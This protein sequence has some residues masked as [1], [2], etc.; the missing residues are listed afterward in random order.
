MSESN[1]LGTKSLGVKNFSIVVMAGDGIGKEVMPPCLELIKAAL[2]RVEANVAFDFISVAAG[3]EYY[4]EYGV[5]ISEQAFAQCR[6]AD[7]ILLGAMGMPGVRY[8]NGTEI[9]PQLELRERLDLFA[10]VRPVRSINGLSPPVL[11][12]ERAQAIDFVLIRESV[13]GL[14]SARKKEQEAIDAASDTL[15]C[16]RSGTE[17]VSQF[18]FKLA[19]KRKAQGHRGHV[20]VID[21]ANVLGSL[22]FFRK[23]FFEQAQQY[24]DI[25]AD[26]LYVDAAAQAL[27]LA[28]WQFD[29]LVTENIFGDI[30]SDLGAGLIGGVGFAPSADLGVDNGVFQP[31]H[32]SAPDIAG[33]GIANPVAMFLSAA[34]MLEWMADHYALPPL[35]RAA[36]SI[37]R[38]VDKAFDNASLLPFERGGSATTQNICDEVMAAL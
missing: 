11:H 3:A 37:E 13:E 23:I 35:S 36:E 7:A 4:L 25:T 24:S 5:A 15:L 27:V 6:Q 1:K 10:G 32:G 26:A 20:S 12:D 34:L 8:A 18:A 31:C 14:F 16:T 19:Q 28:P 29:V 2:E 30:L 9:S 17:R 21:K 22:A 38:A 33:K